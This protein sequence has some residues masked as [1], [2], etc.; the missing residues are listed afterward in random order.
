MACPVLP[1]FRTPLLCRRSR[2]RNHVSVVAYV[3]GYNYRCTMADSSSRS[4]PTDS[5]TMRC[6]CSPRLCVHG[7][8]AWDVHCRLD[9]VS[10]G[11]LENSDTS[12]GR[13]DQGLNV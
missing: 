5:D 2:T 12:Y 7:L 9:N 3:Y 11:R 1:R 13:D 8:R 10:V 4:Q 6:I